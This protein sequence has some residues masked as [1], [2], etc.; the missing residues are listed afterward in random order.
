MKI[1][2]LTP[3]TTGRRTYKKGD[4]DAYLADYPARANLHRLASM[5]VI[6]L[7]PKEIA[8]G[9]VDKRRRPKKRKP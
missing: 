3:I 8:V 1:E 5:G 4:G 6:R 7:I 9:K 2:I